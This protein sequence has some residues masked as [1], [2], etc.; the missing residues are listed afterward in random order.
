LTAQGVEL[1]AGGP[2]ALAEHLR[3][4]ITIWGKAVKEAEAKAD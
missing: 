3:N 2:S 4:E 1:V